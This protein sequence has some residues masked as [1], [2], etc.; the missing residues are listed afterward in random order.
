M[1][2]IMQQTLAAPIAYSGIGLHSGK[3]VAM[4]LL[5]GKEN[6]GI[7]FVRTDL[8]GHPEIQA[9]AENV[10]STVKATTV[11]ENGT[12]VFTVEHLMAAFSMMGIDNC[13]IEMSAPEPPVTDGSAAVFCELILQAGR[14]RQSEPRKIYA[15][16]RAFSV[17]EDDK[18]I[19]I[20]PYDGYRISFVSV[21]AHPALG[22]QYFDIE[23]TEEKF[24]QEIAAARTV[25]F[26]SEI[27]QMQQMGLGLGGSI[28]NVVIFDEKKGTNELDF[29]DYSNIKGRS[30]R[31]M[32]HYVGKVYNFIN[33]PK[34][35]KIVVDI[36]FY[37]QN[38]EL[39]T[40]EILVNI[41]E[42]DVKT[43]VKE[44]YNKIY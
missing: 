33:I 40:D 10:S 12:E 39:I 23:L 35:E 38:K 14:I 29:F 18:Y 3:E 4:K 22:T 21:N 6:T 31:M 42:K 41:P 1:K 11:S 30:G 27:K 37:E 34:E 36:P 16:D 15:V 28:E 2:E 19:T 43:E 17:Y 8:S 32:E 20:Q 13:R 7:V 25:G 24:L 44:R 5:P 26:M 9:L